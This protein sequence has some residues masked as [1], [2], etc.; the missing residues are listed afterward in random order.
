MP[1]VQPSAGG[2]LA[3]MQPVTLDT[4]VGSGETIEPTQNS[5]TGFP[6][7]RLKSPHRLRSISSVATQRT[8]RQERVE[9][10]Y[11]GRRAARQGGHDRRE[12]L[13]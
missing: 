7:P 12:A 5:S 3:G 2:I 6:E 10:D 8:F 13:T 1:A 9:A 11:A 4:S